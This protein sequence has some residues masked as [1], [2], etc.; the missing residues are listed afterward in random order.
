MAIKHLIGPGLL[1]TGGS[2][3]YQVTRG[4]STLILDIT[5]FPVAGQVW[6]SGIG[7][8]QAYSAGAIGSQVYSSG[9]KG[10]VK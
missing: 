4:L 5:G 7:K 6:C 2:V 8:G 1:A 3:K 10:Q 9:G